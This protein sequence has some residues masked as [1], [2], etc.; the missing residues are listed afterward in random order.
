MLAPCGKPPHPENPQQAVE[1]DLHDLITRGGVGLR[2]DPSRCPARLRAAPPA[3]LPAALP[4]L[5]QPRWGC[6]THEPQVVQAQ[7]SRTQPGLAEKQ[8]RPPAPTL[9]LCTET[10]Q[11]AGP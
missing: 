2:L 7:P 10:T 4:H 1:R 11:P 5:S 3:R 8:S 6:R 9:G